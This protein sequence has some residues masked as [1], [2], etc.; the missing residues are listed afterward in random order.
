MGLIN[1][2]SEIII[3]NC[4][5]IDGT[6][7][8]PTDTRT[9]F[10]KSGIIKDIRQSNS[11]DESTSAVV[12][13]LK[14]GTLLPGFINTHVHINF[15]NYEHLKKWLFS[16]VTTIREMGIL[17]DA[18]VSEAMEI[19]RIMFTSSNYPRIVMCGKYITAPGG[20]GGSRPI[21]VSTEDEAREK[22]NELIDQGCN[23][24]KTVLEDGYDPSTFGLPKLST[25]LLKAICDEAHKRG[26]LVSAHVSQAHNLE[27]LVEAGIDE[28]AHNVYDPIT[29]VLI[30]KM[31]KKNIYMIPTMNLYKAFSDKFGAPFYKTCVDNLI[32][33]VDAGGKITV[34]TDFI[35][36]ELPWFELG[37]PIYEMQ[38][39]KEAGLS[40]MQII[41]A[42][43]KNASEVLG[44]SE[45]IGTIEKG[46]VADLIA[47]NGNPLIN[48]GCLKDIL[49]VI[50]DGVVVRNELP[51]V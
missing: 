24:I 48:L 7:K 29:D 11:L 4:R 40:N 1:R 32:R 38:L 27:T 49:L 31:V 17:D 43:T 36:E 39:L 30:N 5:L 44:M 19:K 15:N 34:G 20:Y 26:V 10:I 12:I 37:M 6:G 41:V 35:E 22:V 3:K 18:T 16:G 25:G 9:V 42:A 21:S 2:A 14:G 50:K 28:A 47:V 13:D 46:K 51:N 8:E 33:F 23:F 45:R